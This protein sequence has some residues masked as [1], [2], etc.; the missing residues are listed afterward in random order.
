MKAIGAEINW[1]SYYMNDPT[2]VIH[3]DK[4][5]DN[6]LEWS[7]RQL[8]DSGLYYAETKLGWVHYLYYVRPDRGYGGSTFTIKMEDGTYKDLKG[9]WSSNYMAVNVHLGEDRVL[10][11]VAKV[12]EYSLRSMSCTM[13]VVEQCLQE[14]LP[15]IEI[16]K[17]LG[18]YTSQLDSVQ[19]SIVL[20]G[21]VGNWITFKPKGVPSKDEWRKEQRERPDRER[22]LLDYEKEVIQA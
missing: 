20:G 19:S 4:F 2:L 9:P 14:F 6:L 18:P 5:D 12:G 7:H 8:G 10:D 15:D 3:V 17:K 22:G 16:V 1:H 11:V 13:D 21:Q